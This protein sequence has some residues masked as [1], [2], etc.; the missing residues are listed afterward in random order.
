MAYCRWYDPDEPC[1]YLSTNKIGKC[2][3]YIFWNSG[4]SSLGTCKDKQALSVWYWRI[5]LEEPFDNYE[6]DNQ[7]FYMYPEIVNMIEQGDYSSIDGY[8]YEDEMQRL[9]VRTALKKFV[10]NI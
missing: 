8:D 3:Y 4:H 1:N 6:P 2:R 10:S 5:G 9:I 7:K